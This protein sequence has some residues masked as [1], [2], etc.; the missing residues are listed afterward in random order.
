MASSHGL[1]R[2]GPAFIARV[3]GPDGARVE[4]QG[5]DLGGDGAADEGGEGGG[6]LAG[7][8][9][10]ADGP[11]VAGRDEDGPETVDGDGGAEP[12]GAVAPPEP[13]EPVAGRPAVA[14]GP[15]ELEQD[16]GGGPPLPD[17]E[18]AAGEG[19][20]VPSPP[21]AMGSAGAPPQNGQAVNTRGPR[22]P[23]ARA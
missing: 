16:P 9:L 10:R 6:R 3:T 7:A 13:D 1:I 5:H 14:Q 18:P 19:A 12:G 11:A 23:P 2:S 20:A 15:W 8:P 22:G 21:P 4:V 17:L